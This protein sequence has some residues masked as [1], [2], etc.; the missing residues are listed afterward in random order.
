MPKVLE[1]IVLE[2]QISV[3][4]V[5]NTASIGHFYN[6][7]DDLY[8]NYVQEHKIDLILSNI[9]LHTR[10]YLK[11]I[12]YYKLELERVKSDLETIN[13][14]NKAKRLLMNKGLSE[15]DSH[16]FIISKSMEMRI[17]KKKLANLIIEQKIDI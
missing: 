11:E 14:T 4:Y 16:K 3:I 17:S 7:I 8:F 2:K 15:A 1:K 9:I 6:L 13:K 5:T 12:S 10:K